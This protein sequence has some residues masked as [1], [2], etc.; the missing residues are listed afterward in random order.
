MMLKAV[1]ARRIRRPSKQLISTFNPLEEVGVRLAPQAFGVE[2]RKEPPALAALFFAFDG[3]YIILRSAGTWKD[4][5]VSFKERTYVGW[6]EIAS[7]HAFLKGS[8]NSL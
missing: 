4:I 6:P 1:R 3:K 7:C 5:G 2:N 8:E